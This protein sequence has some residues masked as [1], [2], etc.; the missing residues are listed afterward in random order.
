MKNHFF[1]LIELLVVIAI[2]AILAAMLL[3]ALSAARERSLSASCQGNLRQLA[4]GYLSYADEFSYTPPVWSSNRWMNSITPFVENGDVKTENSIFRCPVDRRDGVETSYGINQ[5][6]PRDPE[7]RRREDLLWYGL[8][9]SKIKN[10]SGFI[11]LADACKYYIGKD[12][13]GRGST[14][15]VDGEMVVSG[16]VYSNLALRHQ[17]N[18]NAV[19]ADG[20]AEYLAYNSSLNTASWDYNG[21]RDEDFN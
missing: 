17:M 13:E 10:P 14:V 12:V 8:S 6:Y 20:H 18:F 7:K 21:E 4:V 15:M 11:I 2:I 19:F 1:T 9:F 16:G 3:P 5:T